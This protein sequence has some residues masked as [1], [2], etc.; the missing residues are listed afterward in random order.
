MG[1]RLFQKATAPYEPPPSPF[2]PQ[3]RVRF[4]GRVYTITATTHAHSQL[5]GVRYAVPNWQLRKIR[6]SK[7]V[8]ANI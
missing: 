7:G 8:E 5:E 1:K 2:R 4:E 3:E 6:K